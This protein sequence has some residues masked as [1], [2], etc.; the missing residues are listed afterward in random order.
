MVFKDLTQDHIKEGAL[1]YIKAFN[2]PPWNDKWSEDDAILRLSQMIERNGFYGMIC[3]E[4]N[5]IVAMIL[6]HSEHYYDGTH[7]EI[8]EFCVNPSK[9]GKGMGSLLLNN[10]LENLN[11]K[12]VSKVFLSTCRTLKTEGFYKKNGFESIEEMVIMSKKLIE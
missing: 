7:F 12:G 2:A 4:N 8:K 10:F 1:L 6:G 11:N 5:D 3:Y 9:S